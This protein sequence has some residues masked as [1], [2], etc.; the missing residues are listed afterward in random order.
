VNSN[1]KYH[2]E[3]NIVYPVN[4]V[5]R[6]SAHHH[7]PHG[8]FGSSH[9]LRRE[10]S[11]MT[12]KDL[13]ELYSTNSTGGYAQIWSNLTYVQC[14]LDSRKNRTIYLIISYDSL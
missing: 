11:A 4:K 2:N 13:A 3:S 1:T 6:R 7:K 14:Q 12:I 9:N 5:D 8:R 10:F